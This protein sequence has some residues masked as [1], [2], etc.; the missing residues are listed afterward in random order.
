MIL[1]ATTTST[2]CAIIDWALET[3]P[4]T[5][6]NTCTLE[7][8]AVDFVGEAMHG[9]PILAECRVSED[10]PATFHPAVRSRSTGNDY[11]RVI[12]RWRPLPK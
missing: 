11:A 10:H 6:R 1:N 12:T 2:T 4:L 5:V 8:L 9:E 7:M 3:A